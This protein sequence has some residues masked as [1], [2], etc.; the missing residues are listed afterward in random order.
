MS[1]LFGAITMISMGLWSFALLADLRQALWTCAITFF[2]AIVF[3][4][5][6]I[7][8]LDIYLMRSA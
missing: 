4:Q 2:D 7:A 1:A 3:V 5:A 6:R 8:M